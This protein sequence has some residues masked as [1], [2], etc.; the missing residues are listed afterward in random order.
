VNEL[1]RHKMHEA[2][3]AEPPPAGLRGRVI[4]SIP[5]LDRT[6]RWQRR[7]RF[8][9]VGPWATG[10]VAALLAVAVV[11]GL[12]YSR[13]AIT[14][15]NQDRGSHPAS[16]A[17]LVSPEG[18]A[19]ARDG[20]VYVSDFVGNRVYRLLPGGRLVS[21]AGGGVG[22]DGKAT[23]ANLWGP[24]AL[25]VDPQGTLFVADSHGGSVRRID[26]QGVI[27]TVTAL[28]GPQGLALD[29]AGWLYV[30]SYYGELRV[31]DGR[32]GSTSLDLSTVPPPT[33][34]VG[35][36]AF[37]AAGNLNFSDPAPGPTTGT[38]ANPAGGCRIIRLNPAQKQTQPANVWGISV[39]AG[40]G[41]CGFSGDGGPAKFAQLNDPNGIVFDA[42]GNLYFADSGNHRIRRIDKNGIITTVA[43]TGIAGYSGDGGPA[44]RAQLAY[45]LGMGIT[46]GGLIYIADASCSCI[47]PATPSHVRALRISDGTIT[48]VAGG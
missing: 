42:D 18:I 8:Q 32:G 11:A 29:T 20:T 30:G 35:Y 46:S 10:F 22:G 14:L 27:S 40:T 48:T 34:Q 25:A 2:L 36:M 24:G 21:I 6:E 9:W 3:D 37:D 41:T 23:D 26:R 5:I 28:Y 38:Y 13:Q 43:G 47:D 1:I 16:P 39:I 44:T 31:I 15:R 33:P 17:R 7:P 19:V 12:L 4:G 45:P